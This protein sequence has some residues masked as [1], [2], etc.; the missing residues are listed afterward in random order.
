MIGSPDGHSGDAKLDP[1]PSMPAVISQ[2]THDDGG[3]EDEGQRG[4]GFGRRVAWP[5]REYFPMMK[6]TRMDSGLRK[7]KEEENKRR[8]RHGNARRT[9]E[10]ERLRIVREDHLA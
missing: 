4:H 10:R 2:R 7:R 9:N 1:C 8:R 3:D 6:L 5:R